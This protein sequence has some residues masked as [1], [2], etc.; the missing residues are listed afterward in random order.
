[1]HHLLSDSTCPGWF[2]V[3]YNIINSQDRHRIYCPLQP[4][5]SYGLYIENLINFHLYLKSDHNTKFFLLIP[6]V[7]LLLILWENNSH[8]PPPYQVIVVNFGFTTITVLRIYLLLFVFWE[9]Q[10]DVYVWCVWTWSGLTLATRSTDEN[11]ISERW[12]KVTL[13]NETYPYRVMLSKPQPLTAY[14]YLHLD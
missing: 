10:C 9:N 13:A 7:L 12:M 14:N 4:L 1:M 2:G 11:P 6:G 5:T 8:L 3:P